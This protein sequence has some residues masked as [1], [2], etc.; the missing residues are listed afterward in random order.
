MIRLILIVIFAIIIFFASLIMLPVF[1]LI[2]KFNQEAKDRGS[3][4]F[5]QG[6]FKVVLFL[7]G[8]TTTV[9]GL[10]NLPK[11]KEAV[12][13]V[14]NHHGFFDTIISYTYMKPRTGFVAKKEIEKVP[15]LNIWMRYLYCLFLDRKNMKE[16]LKT[17][18]TG[19]DYLKA[20]TSIVIFPEGTRNKSND[21]VLPFHAGS[22]K[23]A[24]KSSCKIIPM[25]QNN[26]AAVLEDHLP[27]FKKTH[28]VLE[29]GKPIDVASMDREQKKTLAKDVQDLIEKM[30]E[31][32]I[33][34]FRTRSRS[35]ECVAG[36]KRTFSLRERRLLSTDAFLRSEAG[37]YF[38]LMTLHFTQT[39]SSL[40]F[41]NGKPCLLVAVPQ[42]FLL[43][44]YSHLFSCCLFAYL[45]TKAY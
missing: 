39:Y 29:F 3:L 34:Q 37:T 33:C 12:L 2:G 10:E 14:G 42:R 8:V 44:R 5:V 35:D 26:T 16:G 18:L 31:E 22:F 41:P 32:N 15:L 4:R 19:I 7:S 17:I 1:W 36:T 11:D 21:G 20:G 30:Y 38:R 43:M 27:F 6:V 40:W 9:K 23:L 45:L 13:F 25:V 24:E 28:T